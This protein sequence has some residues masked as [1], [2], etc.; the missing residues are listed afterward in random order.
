MARAEGQEPRPT[1]A[2]K[3]QP[4]NRR[5]FKPR[6]PACRGGCRE[7]PR[8]YISRQ[9]RRQDVMGKFVGRCS[10]R[11]WAGLL[12]PGKGGRGDWHCCVRAGGGTAL[13]NGRGLHQP[14]FGRTSSG[15]VEY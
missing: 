13:G 12:L 3:H 8:D 7:S 4:G 9:A 6:A 15:P 5:R 2:A 10:P 11:G 14:R 1:S